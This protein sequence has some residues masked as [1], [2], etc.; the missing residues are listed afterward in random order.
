LL[1]GTARAPGGRNNGGT[2]DSADA[3]PA[4]DGQASCHIEESALFLA[5]HLGHGPGVLWPEFD[6]PALARLTRAVPPA[7]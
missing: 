3:V 5:V 7:A 1:C 6:Q 4:P 2:V